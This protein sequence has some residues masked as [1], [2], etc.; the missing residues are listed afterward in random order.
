MTNSPTAQ[1]KP[2]VPGDTPEQLV[3]APASD[4]GL[5]DDTQCKAGCRCLFLFVCDEGLGHN[6][7][8]LRKR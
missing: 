6:L 1:K 8:P 4:P 7:T 2:K 5:S 3:R